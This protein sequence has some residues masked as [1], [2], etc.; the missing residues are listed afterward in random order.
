M[1]L[2]KP[3]PDLQ[4]SGPLNDPRT[5]QEYLELILQSIGE[6]VHGVDAAGRITFVNESAATMLGWTPQDLL[7]RQQHALI[8][9]SRADGTPYPEDA[10]PILASLREGRVFRQDG[11]VF[12]RKDGS[13]FPVDYVATPISQDGI[14]VGAVV[15]FR[16]VTDRQ[17]VARQ[18]ALEQARRSEGE[19]LS[20]ELQ[21]VF[22][23]V[24]AAVCTTRGPD[25]IIESANP[26]Y[27]QLVGRPNVI[28]RSTRELLPESSG[29]GAE[30]LDHVYR[31]GEP[32]AGN[33]VKR[34]WDR[35]TGVREEGF[36]NF[37][38]QP[39]RD[40]NGS[41][42]GV[43]CHFV[44]VTE[45]VRSR[46]LVEAHAEEL[47]RVTQSL[48]RMNRELDQFA[49]VA[50]H[51]L[52]APLRGIASL[53][54]WIEDDLGAKLGDESRQHLALLRSRITRMGTLIDGLLQFS[55]AGRVRNRIE[56]VDVAELLGDVIEMLGPGPQ[57]VIKITAGMPTFET[58]RV[59]LAQ[60]FQNLM[61]NAIKHSGR[62]D[63][64]VT[65]SVR[66]DGDCYEFSVSDNGVG[67]PPQFHSKVWEMF[68]TLQPRDKVEGAGLGLAL[69]KKNVENRGGRTWLE[70]DG[71]HGATFYFQWPKHMEEDSKE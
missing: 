39:L 70:S 54:S 32:Y 68:Q 34:V 19:R 53:A 44:D 22:M 45:L 8:H 37:V 21:R 48:S 29:D 4:T 55:R 7:G 64:I 60:V 47:D 25:H 65:I 50:S 66:D 51:D 67:I 52:K 49:Y 35:G 57:A 61:G 17:R 3:H 41:V 12:W 56:T 28:G 59:P 58:E 20:Q 23:Q 36:V 10:C 33:E 40:L 27:Q 38:Y 42:Y 5:R 24:P 2:R 14:T 6:G 62:P 13:S 26:R 71:R 63:V 1:S 9:H 11:D 30:M 69:V 31:S 46:G 18:L 15:A 16:D 43:M